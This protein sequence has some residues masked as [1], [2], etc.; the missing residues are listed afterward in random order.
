VEEEF[1]DC[2]IFLYTR[3]VVALADILKGG[4]Q[5]SERD[6]SSVSED[7]LINSMRSMSEFIFMSLVP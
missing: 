6:T 2:D 3:T 4:P 5:I 1:I 7:S